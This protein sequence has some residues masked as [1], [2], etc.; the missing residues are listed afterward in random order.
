LF[1]WYLAARWA[2]YR[3]DDFCA[4]DAAT[5][6]AFHV[7]AYRCQMQLDAILAKEATRR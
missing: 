3:W 5:E 4:L 1:E 6:Q 2:G 7:A